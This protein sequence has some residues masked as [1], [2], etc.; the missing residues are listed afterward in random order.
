MRHLFLLI[1][2]LPIVFAGIGVFYFHLQRR[3]AG[4]APATGFMALAAGHGAIS[5]ARFLEYYGVVNFEHALLDTFVNSIGT[6]LGFLVWT[7]VFFCLTLLPSGPAAEHRIGRRLAFTMLAACGCLALFFTRTIDFSVTRLPFHLCAP[8]ALLLVPVAA[9]V[10][11]LAGALGGRL[12]GRS[13]R[14]D[15]TLDS[16]MAWLLA[17]YALF[18]LSSL[19]TPLKKWIPTIAVFGQNIVLVVW[20][21]RRRPIPLASVTGEGEIMAF[22]KSR[23]GVSNRELDVLAMLLQGK[24]NKE[25]EEALFIS[26]HTIRNHIAAL[27]RK[28]GVN[29]RGQLM[30]RVLQ[31]QKGA[32]HPAE[33]IAP[34]TPDRNG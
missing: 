2:L 19:L 17:G 16:L 20:Y 27:Y 33:T 5:L 34:S 26:P 4:D 29:S 31:L 22:F 9:C 14:A 23:Y 18:L 3:F 8:L 12:L 21:K 13:P 7:G 1:Q 32:M 28:I 30:N 10:L 15:R 24:K 11:F 25:I 6:T